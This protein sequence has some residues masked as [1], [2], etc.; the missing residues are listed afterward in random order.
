MGVTIA[1][2]FCPECRAEFKAEIARCPQCVVA[3]VAEPLPPQ[4]DNPPLLFVESD[5]VTLFESG[6]PTRLALVKVRLDLEEIP[7]LLKGEGLQ[8]L[9]GWGTLGNYN[10]ITGP[11]QIKVLKTD[12]EAALE[13]TKDLFPV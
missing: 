7:Y 13:A 6:D 5:L 1:G 4:T 9:F 10:H 2:M 8:Q 3:L 12:A 11:A